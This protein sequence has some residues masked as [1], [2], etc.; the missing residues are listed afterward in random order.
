[1]SGPICIIENNEKGEF[2][3]NQ[4]ALNIL[5]QITQHVVVV[6]IAGLYR[7]G[8]SYLLNRLAGKTSGF[9]LGSTVESKTKG[10]WMWCV[11]HPMNP[12]LTLVLLDTEGLGDVQK[13]DRK[14]DTWIFSLA[15]LLSSTLVYNSMGTIDNYAIENLHFVTELADFIKVKSNEDE[16]E[17]DSN[18][19]QFFPH[20]VWVV[21]DMTLKLE[22]D[23]CKLTADQYLEKALELKKGVKKSISEY[24]LPRQCIRKYFP[25][26]KCFTFVRPIS[27]NNFDKLE[28]IKQQDLDR[29]FVQQSLNFCDHILNTAAVKVVKGGHR[30]TGK[31]FGI[32]VQTYVKTIQ[33]GEVPC[34][35]N[36]VI[37][38]ATVENEQAVKEALDHYKSKMESS[39]NFPTEDKDLSDTHQ[40]CERESIQIFMKRSFKDEEQKYQLILMDGI[41]VTYMEFIE[42]NQSASRETC[43]T[44]L[45][46][47]SA[48]LDKNFAD[49]VYTKPGGFQ[50]YTQD[51]DLI[52]QSFN[53]TPNKGVKAEETLTL[54]LENKKAEAESILKADIN[55]S[56]AQKKLA[57]E[58]E[59]ARL[60]EQ[61]KRQ[62]EERRIQLEQRMKD[63]E[64]THEET[65]RQLRLKMEM[66]AKDIKRE[67]EGAMESKLREQ[68]LLLN[69]GFKEQANTMKDEINSLKEQLNS[70]NSIAEMISNVASAVGRGL[71]LAFRLDDMVEEENQRKKIIFANKSR[72]Y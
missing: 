35:E 59:K 27:D 32:L 53:R 1:M 33:S 50:L 21:R 58:Q 65:M 45:K 15:V 41:V 56:D 46:K 72:R 20:F 16:Y 10:I 70:R 42:K 38:M 28:S 57:E 71:E 37:A 52:V 69:Q 64:Q 2:H 34:M 66:Q 62:E 40:V 26:R 63:Q 51:R 17:D 49:G 54:Y 14:N 68:Q 30:L 55:L 3:V 22:M 5:S 23:N 61:N 4:Q 67:V 7:T 18:L 19:V 36:A 48:T 29:Q 47:L 43:I 13:G 39:L 31:L 12:G 60:L 9:P 6:A 11:P 8:K 44:L 24:N 25:S